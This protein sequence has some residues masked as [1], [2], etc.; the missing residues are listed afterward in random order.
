[1][2]GT[3]T[4]YVVGGTSSD[5]FVTTKESRRFSEMP[6]LP[7]L[8]SMHTNG[9]KLSSHISKELISLNFHSIGYSSFNAPAS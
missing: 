2:I 4:A 3:K 1:M 7:P 8:V 9:I 5:D 6:A